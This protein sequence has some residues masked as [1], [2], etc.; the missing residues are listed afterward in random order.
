[1]DMEIN[2]QSKIITIR[3][4]IPLLQLVELLKKRIE[5]NEKRLVEIEG[6]APNLAYDHGGDVMADI[7]LIETHGADENDGGVRWRNAFR[8]AY[9]V[10][11]DEIRGKDVLRQFSRTLNRRASVIHTQAWK[12]DTNRL[13]DRE[14]ILRLCVD[15]TQAWR[16]N[17]DDLLREGSRSMDSFRE[18]ERIWGRWEPQ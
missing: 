5:K 4:G 1:M 8:H 17:R 12:N 16:D 18:L 15:I 9:G 13:E 6:A 10:S 2:R 11:F 3:D 7:Y 14:E